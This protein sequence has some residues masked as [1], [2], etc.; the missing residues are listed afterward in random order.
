M[1]IIR[2]KTLIAIAV[3][4]ACAAYQPPPPEGN[5]TLDFSNAQDIFA[6]NFFENGSDCS[7][8]WSFFKGMPPL[9]Q[10]EKTLVVK[11][12]KPIALD[13]LWLELDPPP[14]TRCN[15]LFS[16]IPQQNKRYLL[17]TLYEEGKC[18]IAISTPT[19]SSGDVMKNTQATQR[20][21]SGAGVTQSYRCTP[22]E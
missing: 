16:F 8:K 3:L 22:K 15:V 19:D 9:S 5:A 13:L 2:I 17:N 18:S 14:G 10:G 4:P 7:E 21:F 20:V 12:G 1:N 11:A 6:F